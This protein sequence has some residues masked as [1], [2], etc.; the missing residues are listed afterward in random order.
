MLGVWNLF[1]QSEMFKK[2][3][4]YYVQILIISFWVICHGLYLPGSA[5]RAWSKKFLVTSTDGE[6]PCVLVAACFRVVTLSQKV[7]MQLSAR[8]MRAVPFCVFG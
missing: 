7:F 8:D 6:V 1:K 5:P 2:R 3:L 4:F